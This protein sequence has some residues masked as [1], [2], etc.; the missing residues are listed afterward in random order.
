MSHQTEHSRIQSQIAAN[1]AALGRA[2]TQEHQ[3]EGWRADVL[4]IKGS[5]VIAFEVQWSGQSL[6]RTLARQAR[7]SQAGIDCCWLFQK[8]PHKLEHERPDLPIFYV[9][10]AADGQFT[11]SLSGRAEIPLDV[12]VEQ[13]LE[14]GVRFCKAARTKRDQSVTLVF[15]EMPCWKCGVMNH[16]YYVDGPVFASCN[17]EIQPNEALWESNRFGHRPEV[18]AAAREFLSSPQGSHLRLGE[19]KP[20][21]SN[22][23]G[24][25]YV[26]FGCYACD[27]IFGDW[28]VMNAELDAMNDHGRAGRFETVICLE[29]AIELALPHWCYPAGGTFCDEKGS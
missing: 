19:I 10:K 28:Y 15:Y 24:K 1:C 23:V 18:I 12:F 8:P 11:V 16:L 29:S 5:K 2:V 3:G 25:A 27:S 21:H 22:T 26:S 6:A 13:F 20:R 17:A 9:S 4:A 14:G 7:Y